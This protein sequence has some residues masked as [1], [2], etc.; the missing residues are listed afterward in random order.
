MY[1]PQIYTL[2]ETAE[3]GSFAKAAERLHISPVSVMNQINA[4]EASWGVRLFE[5]TNR[6]VVL[7]AAGRSLCADAKRIIAESEAAVMRAR[8]I[9]GAERRTVRIGTS[10]LRPCAPLLELWKHAGEAAADFQINIAP[11]SDD[12]SGMEKM[13][14]SLGTDIDCFVSPCDSVEWMRRFRVVPLFTCKCR[15]AAPVTHRLASKEILSWDDME[16]ERLMLVRR[17]VSRVLDRMRDEIEARR[18]GIAVMDIP[19]LYDMEVFNECERGNCLMEVP[20]TWAG[21][22]P[23]VVTLP[24]EWDYEMPFGVVCAKRPS[25]VFSEFMKIVERLIKEGAGA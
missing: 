10:V 4:L 20:E 1:N 5:R 24:V 23:S 3:A 22:H 18:K 16:G 25:P 6:G 17:G 7:T 8:E 21:V 2:I 15:L 12:P 11:F 19:N 9:S 14:E 13:L